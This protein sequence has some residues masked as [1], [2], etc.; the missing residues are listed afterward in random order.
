MY[1]SIKGKKTIIFHF[2]QRILLNESKQ[3]QCEVPLYPFIR[4]HLT[5]GREYKRV[6]KEKGRTHPVKGVQRCATGKFLLR[7][8]L[9]LLGVIFVCFYD[10]RQ[11]FDF[12]VPRYNFE[13]FT[14]N[15]IF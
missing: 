15:I 7:F 5:P 9:H 14:E 2:T 3:V 10:E 11:R 1:L 12:F 4:R 6:N 13:N 8:L